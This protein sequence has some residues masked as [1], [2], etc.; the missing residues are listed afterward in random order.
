M[1]VPAVSAD[2][3]ALIRD[4]VDGTVVVLRTSKAAAPENTRDHND[5]ELILGWVELPH[6]TSRW[7]TP[8]E[9][10]AAALRVARGEPLSVLGSVRPWEGR[11]A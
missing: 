9:V 6:G 2:T 7:H 8:A 10:S 3:L 5:D 11:P 4:H 1:Y